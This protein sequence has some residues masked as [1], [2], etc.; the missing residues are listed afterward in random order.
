[1]K[2]II[3]LILIIIFMLT[4]CTEK[5][6]T[7][8]GGSGDS[9]ST[10]NS[11]ID[12]G[13]IC[14]QSLQVLPIEE[15]IVMK[16]FRKLEFGQKVYAVYP[17]AVDPLVALED[18]TYGDGSSSRFYAE[19]THDYVTSVK[20]DVIETFDAISAM[21]GKGVIVAPQILTAMFRVTLTHYSENAN[22]LQVFVRAKG[23]IGEWKSIIL[24]DVG[25]DYVYV[26]TNAIG[27]LEYYIQESS[28]YDWIDDEFAEPGFHVY[29][30]AE[31]YIEVERVYEPFE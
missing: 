19:N 10:V 7:S 26:E 15:S 14:N 9:K 20:Y 5:S 25:T 31:A 17:A 4:S 11:V 22:P 2:K 1:M 23:S 21:A 27:E 18:Y 30:Y 24:S 6:E 3:I 12:D 16:F 28:Y 13:I 29:G 8:D